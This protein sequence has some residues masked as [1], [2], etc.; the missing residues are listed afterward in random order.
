MGMDRKRLLR[1][2]KVGRKGKGKEKRIG[3]RVRSNM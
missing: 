2:G 3:I 1:E